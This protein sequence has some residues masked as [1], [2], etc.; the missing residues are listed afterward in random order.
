MEERR[1]DKSVP[2]PGLLLAKQGDGKSEGLRQ[3]ASITF[4]FAASPGTPTPLPSHHQPT[5]P[6]LSFCAWTWGS[7]VCPGVVQKLERPNQTK[8]HQTHEGPFLPSLPITPS[9]FA[10]PECITSFLLGSQR[11]SL[12]S[13]RAGDA[14]HFMFVKVHL[15]P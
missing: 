3:L 15:I 13:V 5:L 6:G 7:R 11:G 14:K 2:A 1:A 4:S 10:Q 8:H 9:S 12:C